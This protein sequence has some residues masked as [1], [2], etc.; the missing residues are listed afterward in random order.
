MVKFGFI[1]SSNL[2]SNQGIKIVLSAVALDT[3]VFCFFGGSNYAVRLQDLVFFERVEL[4]YF[5]LIM[6]VESSIP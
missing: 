1:S 5:S 2:T 4:Q 6:A 3:I